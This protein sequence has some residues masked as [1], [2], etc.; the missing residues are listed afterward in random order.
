M[1]KI[2]F[3]PLPPRTGGPKRRTRELAT[4]AAALVKS[5]GEWARVGVYRNAASAA[6][7]ASVIKRGRMAAFQPHG[8][9]EAASRTV[10]GQAR[11]Y[12]RFVGA[13]AG[14]EQA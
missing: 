14:G 1:S 13:P 6:S 4:I 7:M 11:V 5:P 10:D 8:A 9:F 12:A 2:V 3:E